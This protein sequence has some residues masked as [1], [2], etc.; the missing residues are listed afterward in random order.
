MIDLEARNAKP[1]PIVDDAV[2]LEFAGLDTH[3]VG[4]K[5][6]IG[7]ADGDIGAEGRFQMLCQTR[8]PTGPRTRIG[9]ARRPNLPASQPVNQRSGRPTRWSEW[10]CVSSNKSMLPIGIPSWNRRIVAPRPASTRIRWAPAS[11]SVAGPNL[12]GSGAGMPLPSKVT[13]NGVSMP[14]LLLR[15]KAGRLDRRGPAFDV[16]T[17]NAGKLLR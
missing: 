2:P 6:F 4:R 7:D 1:I 10:K 8:V 16:F 12:S 5:A 3:T 13:L 17:L 11:T 14:L 9:E 15:F